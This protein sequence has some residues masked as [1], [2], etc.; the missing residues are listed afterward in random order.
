MISETYVSL[1]TYDI[2]K[3]ESSLRVLHSDLKTHA[4]GSFKYKYYSYFK[5][6]RGRP[7]RIFAPR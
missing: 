5:W 2:I 3:S 4:S 6:L 7:T 1:N